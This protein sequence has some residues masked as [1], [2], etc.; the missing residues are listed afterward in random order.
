MNS[1][2][3]WN[4][5]ETSVSL[6]HFCVWPGSWECFQV[7]QEI[8]QVWIW[9]QRDNR[10][11]CLTPTCCTSILCSTMTFFTILYCHIMY[12]YVLN[13]VALSKHCG[14]GGGKTGARPKDTIAR[15]CVQHCTPHFTFHFTVHCNAGTQTVVRLLTELLY[16]TI[17]SLYSGIPSTSLHCT[18]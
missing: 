16:P 14:E 9:W 11:L 5:G 4:I 8:P 17:W 1:L 2:N 6:W 15:Y 13:S 3:F 12:Y 18:A 7:F 10:C